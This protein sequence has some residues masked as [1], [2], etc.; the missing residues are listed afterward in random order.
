MPRGLVPDEKDLP[1]GP[2]EHRFEIL[3]HKVRSAFLVGLNVGLSGGQVERPVES[4]LVVLLGD[5]GRALLADRL[6]LPA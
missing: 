1:F 2:F 3:D 6:S 4:P 5:I